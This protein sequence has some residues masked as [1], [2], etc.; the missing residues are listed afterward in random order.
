MLTAPYMANKSEFRP[1]FPADDWLLHSTVQ[2][3]DAPEA[4]ACGSHI[5]SDYI[6]HKGG[7]V[8]PSC[9]LRERHEH[10]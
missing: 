7:S 9:S 5:W 1:E 4:I 10:A 3:I 8:L 6:F 2:P